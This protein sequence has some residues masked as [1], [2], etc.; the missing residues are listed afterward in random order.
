VNNTN[1]IDLY[2]L[3]PAIYRIRDSERGYPLRALL[4]L[5][6]TQAALVK[7]DIDG[8]WDDL[9]IETCAD[10][11]VPYV[12][13]LVANNPIYG[14]IVRRRTDVAH[15]IY[16][17]RRKGTLTMLEQLA[18]DATGWD[19]HAV[20]F[21]EELG[22][23]QNLNHIRLNDVTST[24][25]M[26]P[27]AV[28]RVGTVLLR[29]LDG[30]DRIDGPFDTT[31]H[32][33]D[34]RPI[35]Q[36]EG[37]YNIQNVGFFIWRLQTFFTQEVTPRRSPSFAEGFYFS[38][39][40][41][42]VPLFVNPQ[43]A[44]LGD[45][46]VTEIQVQSPIRKV[47]FYFRP[48]DY[49]ANPALPAPSFAIYHGTTANPANLIP[50]ANIVCGDLTNWIAPESG[51]I[52]VDVE[53][54]R[55]A[56]APG[57]VPE[58]GV[59]VSY[60]YGFSGPMGG[61][62][63]DRTLDDLVA[64][65]P[66]PEIPG[67]VA[68]PSALGL[69]IRVPSAGINTLTQA[70]AQW[71][72]AVTPQAVIQIEDNRTYEENLTIAFPTIAV[73]PGQPAPMLVLQAADLQR[74]TLIGN[75]AVTGGTGV[76]ELV[77]SGLLMAG[78]LHVEGNLGVVEIV[79]S[80]LVS[81]LQ[82]D[83]QGQ[84]V[85]P[86]LPSII[87]DAPGDALQVLID[88]SITGRLQL[89]ENVI[90]LVVRDSIIDSPR[91]QG[92]ADFTPALVS[93]NLSPFPALSS[94][95]PQVNVT[96]G[97]EGPY[98]AKLPSVPTT[99]AEARDALQQ[100]IQSVH[101]TQPFEQTRVL[102]AANR[103]IIVPGGD[104]TIVIEVADS[105]A[106]ATELRLDAQSSRQTS[107]VVSGVLSPFPT[108][109]SPAPQLTATIGEE[110]QG[111]ATFG[112][113]PTS[114]A[115]ARD[116]LQAAI[117]AA[118]ASAGFT[119]AV[120]VNL[121]NQLV[122]MSGEGAAPITFSNTAADTTT[123]TQ[124]AL[125][126][127]RPAIA[128]DDAG[129][130]PGPPS[131]LLR[132]TILGDVHV[133]QLPLATEV[134]FASIVRCARRQNGC[135]RFSFVPEG[136]VTPRRYRCQPDFEIQQQTEDA[137]RVSGLLS[138][139]DSDAIRDDVRSWLQ[140]SFTDI[141]YGLPGYG[142]LFVLCPRQIQTGAEDGSEMGAFCFLKQPQRATSLRVRLQEYLPFGLEPGLIYVT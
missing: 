54:G 122:V 27:Y 137:E 32:T 103:L 107:A 112:S 106:T 91:R 59:T 84:P 35:G 92:Q 8:L 97:D 44:P 11:V 22:L 96:I 123:L 17:R 140:P 113:V 43:P 36:V 119:G 10:W 52:A 126:T 47:A 50:L 66:G 71:N 40:G 63:Y 83:E 130:V 29:D 69:L 3:L 102:S 18:R 121:D 48:Q 128:A 60:T 88:H 33:V 28:G 99:L 76:E 58:D 38:P 94:S 24:D 74:P 64:G 111:I 85:L 65:D 72:P 104:E 46:L 25:S 120:V 86:D 115:Q 116:Q 57:E 129:D 133:Q 45:K 31:T 114:I 55:F 90:G 9:F 42:P 125:A 136:S 118:G 5:I 139:A 98:L 82:L 89:P 135:V 73:P 131:W 16:Y 87:V 61:G 93:G 77:V 56:F 49:Y 7:A 53:H 37:W 109:T 51:K 110:G 95:A 20:A 124:L 15:T 13:D 134:I 142:Q 141:H 12:G 75:I 127:E 4:G 62:P 68:D 70:I 79:H 105:D 78:Q 6:S 1:S 41:N 2:S 138:Q 23:S 117:R 132:T 34:V 101:S 67:T 14:N 21:F 30:L 39:L 81:G 100:A 19:A 108:I 26:D 80:T